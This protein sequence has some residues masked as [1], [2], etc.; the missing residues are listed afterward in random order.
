MSKKNKD[1]EVRVEE[2]SRDIKG[3]TYEINQIH[4]GKKLI[5]E[6][7]TMGPKHFQAFLGEEDLGASKTLDLAIEAVL[8]QY[9]LHDQ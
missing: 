6:V 9:N 7:L 2:T 8:M 4:I 5:G 1:I 3:T